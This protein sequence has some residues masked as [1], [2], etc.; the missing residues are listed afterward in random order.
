M[1]CSF[2]KTTDVTVVLLPEFFLRSDKKTHRRTHIS[3]EKKKKRNT[4]PDDKPDSQVEMEPIPTLDTS[5]TLHK[6]ERC[7]RQA[8]VIHR[9]QFDPV[10]CRYWDYSEVTC[11]RCQSLIGT[12]HCCS[13]CANTR[14]WSSRSKP[15]LRKHLRRKHPFAD[16]SVASKPQPL[17][18]A[19]PYQ[20]AEDD[21]GCVSLE[22]DDELDDVGA[23]LTR[24]NEAHVVS[25]GV[26]GIAHLN[27]IPSLPA[28]TPIQEYSQQ[29]AQSGAVAASLRIA[30]K[31]TGKT[32]AVGDSA[33]NM[34][35]DWVL[36]FLLVVLN[37]ALVV[38][39]LSENERWALA[40]IVR[41]FLKH[42][43][44]HIREK[45][46]IPHTVNQFAKTH[47]KNSS[48]SSVRCSLPIPVSVRSETVEL[49]WVSLSDAIAHALAMPP[50]PQERV[51]HTDDRYARL[52]RSD[53]YKDI[54]CRR[55]IPDGVDRGD[56]FG[57]VAF[58][59]LWSDGWDPNRL[60]KANRGSVWALTA[61]IIFV[62]APYD[63]S[64]PDTVFLVVTQLL[65][66][67]KEKENHGEYFDNLLEELETKFR[68]SDGKLLPRVAHSRD[69]NRSVHIHADIG[70]VLQD[71]PERRGGLG[72]LAGN[73]VAHPMFGL[74]CNFVATNLPIS[75]CEDCKTAVT[76]CIRSKRWSR[77]LDISCP[78]CH[79]WSV[80]SLVS[81]GSLAVDANRED[82]MQAEDP[83][84]VMLSAPTRITFPVLKGMWERCVTRYC[85]SLEYSET[86]VKKYFKLHCVRENVAVQ[87]CSMCRDHLM[88]K[89]LLAGDKSF[90]VDDEHAE[91]VAEDM[92]SRP[93]VYSRPTPP[94][95]WSIAPIEAHVEAPMHLAMNC[96]KSVLKTV[97]K[98]HSR[99]GMGAK[100]CRRFS[101]LL[102]LVESLKLEDVRAQKFNDG[103][104]G[105]YVAENFK[106]L[107]LVLPWLSLVCEDPD[108]KSSSSPE[109]AGAQ[110]ENDDPPDKWLV[111]RC[112]DWLDQRGLK[113]KKGMNRADLR[114]L[115]I[116]WM[117]RDDCP[118]A[119]PLCAPG[120]RHPA[121]EPTSTIRH[122]MLSLHRLFQVMFATDLRGVEARNRYEAFAAA[123][124]TQWDTVDLITMPRRDKPVYVAKYNTMGLMRC[125]E[126]FLRY[127]DVASTHE[128]GAMGEGLVKTLRSMCPQAARDLWSINLV[129][130]FYRAK[131]LDVVQGDLQRKLEGS[132]SNPRKRKRHYRRYHDVDGAHASDLLRKM[133]PISLVQASFP[134]WDA[135]K[136]CLHAEKAVVPI[137]VYQDDC[138]SDEGGFLCVRLEAGHVLLPSA[139]G[140]L[141]EGMTPLRCILALPDIREESV[142]SCSCRYAL[143]SHVWE[144]FDGADFVL[145]M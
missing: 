100:L 120:A 72:L 118:E 11:D 36:E 13:A 50:P 82:S 114:E 66:C 87:F 6:C 143:V 134:V 76:Q 24:Q 130:S 20:V 89:A 23:G 113:H 61:S 99:F 53:A 27:S 122:L 7:H 107:T 92:E 129:D 136:L 77:R 93:H 29:M 78:A 56:D 28:T 10:S 85:D 45:I 88:G 70:L 84:A 140:A 97:I 55:S 110:T 65:S 117:S 75:S 31:G 59:V 68:R 131:T 47:L 38:P 90:F 137:E 49:S 63:D 32:N 18:V 62:K 145:G 98:Y 80:D 94:A 121:N 102:A 126:T 123:F 41:T 2:L 79:H 35:L 40:E 5:Q 128:G 124:L 73:S 135:P 67:G 48:S 111:G 105:G 8:R 115:V 91:E 125:A 139:D 81:R 103:K 71:N 95:S 116:S 112:R 69:L 12:L 46:E 14:P 17:D 30:W 119:V 19:D 4:L 96:Q 37:L 51:D 101:D 108:L 1:L 57:V 44:K 33:G 60:S 142:Q 86:D 26:P 3:P 127:G 138:Y 104:F 64:K 9:T 144:W 109:D 52:V 83:A 106:A 42:T 34:V 58:V 39:S 43:P 25:E 21:N 133:N 141:P 16:P 15:T 74:H 132:A 22:V 54:K